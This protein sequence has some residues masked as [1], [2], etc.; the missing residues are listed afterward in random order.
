M[1]NVNNPATV[2]ILEDVFNPYTVYILEE[3][4]NPYPVNISD[5]GGC[6]QFVNAYTVYSAGSVQPAHI[7]PCVFCRMCSFRTQ[8]IFWR[9]FTILIPCTPRNPE[10]I[11]NS[12][13]VYILE[14]VYNPNTVY[15]A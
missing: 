9:M 15:T 8:F 7:V 5:S 3:L 6:V 14:E 13:T 2:Y 12:Y 10:D 4:Y 1:E 11:F